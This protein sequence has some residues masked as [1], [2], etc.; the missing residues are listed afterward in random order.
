MFTDLKYPSK[1]EGFCKERPVYTTLN[2]YGTNE[3]GTRTHC[4]YQCLDY[5]QGSPSTGKQ[6]LYYGPLWTQ[7]VTKC[8]SDKWKRL[9]KISNSDTI[10][11]RKIMKHCEEMNVISGS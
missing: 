9:G 11:S 8:E 3:I 10:Q 2:L 6:T 4:P 1:I 5:L 7:R